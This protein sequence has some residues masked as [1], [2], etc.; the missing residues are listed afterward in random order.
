MAL[1]SPDMSIIQDSIIKISDKINRDYVELENLQSSHKG[2]VR[3]VEMTINF[4]EN[5]LFEYF[6]TKKENYDVIFYG[7]DD[8]ADFNS[9]S[10]YIINILSGAI[11]LIHAIPYFCVSIGLQ[12]KDK[13]GVYQTIC[14]LIDN[15]ITQETFM[16]EQGRGAYVNSRRIRVS[17]RSNLENSLIAIQNST[18]KDF[19]VDCV[20]KYKNLNITNSDVLNICNT[21]NG[22]LDATII[23]DLNK[24]YL[25]LPVLLFKEAGGLI[26]EKDNISIL[27]N[28]SLYSQL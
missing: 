27:S 19:L 28:E 20:K 8:E 17:S 6:K 12:K 22:K 10:R 18:N 23:E 26:K 16:V 5:K 7:K 9:N 25:Q 14:G 21:A 13:D 3:F 4:V 2:D 1:F 11:N 24:I 15:P